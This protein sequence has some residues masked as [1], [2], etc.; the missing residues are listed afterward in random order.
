MVRGIIASVIAGAAL[1]G[2]ILYYRRKAA[3]RPVRV[4]LT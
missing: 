2:G 4:R 1:V 3:D